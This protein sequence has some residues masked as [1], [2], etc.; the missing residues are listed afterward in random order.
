VTAH[1]VG[2]MKFCGLKVPHCQPH[3]I[4]VEHELLVDSPMCLSKL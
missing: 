3:K 1:V 2:L 4:S